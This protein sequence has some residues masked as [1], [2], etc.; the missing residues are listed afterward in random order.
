MLHVYGV[1]HPT[2]AAIVFEYD[3]IGTNYGSG[4]RGFTAN[5]PG[6]E[7][8]TLEPSDSTQ[9]F[10]H[11]FFLAEVRR[12]S[13]GLSDRGGARIFALDANNNELARYHLSDVVCWYRS[14]LSGPTPIDM[15]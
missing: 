7:R 12:P 9:T 3:D 2:V 15:D 11:Q 14:P 13:P 6:A 8:I 1:T 10:H 4:D 5:P